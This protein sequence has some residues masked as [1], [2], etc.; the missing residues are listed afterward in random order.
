MEWSALVDG[1]DVG[2][3]EEEGGGRRGGWAEAGDGWTVGRVS[4]CE[5]GLLGSGRLCG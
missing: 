5:A 3:E 1:V 2:E 4:S